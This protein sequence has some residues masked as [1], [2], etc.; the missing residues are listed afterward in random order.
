MTAGLSLSWQ[1][2]KAVRRLEQLTLLADIA[3]QNAGPA[4]QAALLGGHRQRDKGAVVAFLTGADE[5]GRTARAGTCRC[6]SGHAGSPLRNCRTTCADGQ[7]ARPQWP[8]GFRPDRHRDDKACRDRASARY[9]AAEVQGWHCRSP[10]IAN[11]RDAPCARLPAP[12]QSVRPG[13]TGQHPEY[14]GTARSLRRRQGK[15]LTAH[16]PRV[17][18]PYAVRTDICGAAIHCPGH[19]SDRRTFR[20]IV[21]AIVANSAAGSDR[22]ASPLIP[23]RMIPTGSGHCDLGSGKAATLIGKGFLA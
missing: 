7:T 6:W 23:A 15:A 16:R 12:W 13:P 18:N 5:P 20:R 21:S 1:G 10:T 17:F 19:R 8:G 3:G 11:L 14:P 4:R 22:A 9:R 2:G